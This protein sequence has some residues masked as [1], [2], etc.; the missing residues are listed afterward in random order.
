VLTPWQH[1][2]RIDGNIALHYI[3][4]RGPSSVIAFTSVDAFPRILDLLQIIHERS[5][6]ALAPELEIALYGNNPNS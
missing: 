5:G 6:C 2:R 3:V 4:L 1:I